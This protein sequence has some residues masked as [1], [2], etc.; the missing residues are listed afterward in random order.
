MAKYPLSYLPGV[1][2]SNSTFAASQ[3]QG[4]FQGRGATGRITN[5]NLSRFVAGFPEKIGGAVVIGTGSSNGIAVGAS[6]GLKDL[7]DFDGNTYLFIGAWRQLVQSPG[8]NLSVYNDITPLRVISTA[9][10]TNAF[11]TSSG[12]PTVTVTHTAHQQQSGDYVKLGTTT[13]GGITIGGVYTNI[14]V[15][16]TNAY[17]FTAASNATA[18]T[19]A[20]GASAFYYYRATLTNPFITAT[21]ESAITVTHTAHAGSNGDIV[22]IDGAS[23][24]GGITVSSRGYIIS[25]A[26]ANTYRIQTTGTATATAT[27]GGT[28][29]LRYA[30][31][32]GGTSNVNNTRSWSLSP[33]GEQMLISLTND[34]I[35]VWDPTIGG[36]AY[37]LSNAPTGIRAMF[38]TPERFPFALGNTDNP[39]QVKWP[40]QDDYTIWDSLP[41]NT[42]NSRT[43]QEGSYLVG[44]I[45]VRDGV[46]MVFSNTAAYVFTY[47]GDDFIYNSL[48][49]GV[50]CGLI[51][52][53]AVAV[54]GG[55]AYWMSDRDFWMWDGSLQRLPSDDIRDYVFSDLNTTYLDKCHAGTNLAKKEIWFFYPSNTSEDDYGLTET[56]PGKYVIYHIDQ[57]CWSIGGLPVSSYLDRNLFSYPIAHMTADGDTSAPSVYYMDNGNNLGFLLSESTF[58]FVEYAPVSIGNGDQA[59]EIYGLIPDF[60]TFTATN[61]AFTDLELLLL[62]KDQPAETAGTST[63]K[64]YDVST[65]NLLHRIDLRTSARLVGFRIKTS[66]SNNNDFWRLGTPILDVQPGGSRR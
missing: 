45:A 52:P 37:P 10:L 59:T 11:I 56:S 5:M 49:A 64:M 41:S 63:H 65:G 43:L 23:A 66:I 35:Y 60:H 14:T 27:G 39:M 25:T 40:D 20:G 4:G 36:R 13:A 15:T 7:R 50:G 9:T 48:L 2:K 44:G 57:Q 38:V 24:V 61:A 26:S 47:S 28:P 22:T 17:T 54:M 32:V 16:G 46:S 62:T 18:T 55:A 12:S 19:T 6:R 8:T 53:L 34:T 51:A 58:P 21:G 42:A 1:C 33:Y 31:T 29:N 30:I 3:Q